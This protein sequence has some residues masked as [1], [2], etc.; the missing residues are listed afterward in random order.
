MNSGPIYSDFDK[1][2]CIEREIAMR[3]S[4]YPKWVEKG[5][6]KHD[7]AEREI[8]LMVQIAADYKL[9]LNGSH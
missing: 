8:A 6:M 5:K 2:R 7:Q 4:A 9:R 1:L 3:R